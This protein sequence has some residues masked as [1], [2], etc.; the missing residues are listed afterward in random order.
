M[1]D[2]IVRLAR[3]R[4]AR[5]VVGWLVLAALSALFGLLCGARQVQ[6]LGAGFAIA[7]ALDGWVT[8]SEARLTVMFAKGEMEPV[9]PRIPVRVP[10]ESVPV[11]GYSRRRV[12]RL[13]ARRPHPGEAGLWVMMVFPKSSLGPAAK[14]GEWFGGTDG[15]VP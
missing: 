11:S 2:Q 8:V 5:V 4:A 13:L 9:P 10:A 7:A 6:L 14:L 1:A 3:G 12:A 15:V